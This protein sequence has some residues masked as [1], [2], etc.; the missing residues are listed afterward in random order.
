[1]TGREREGLSPTQRDALDHFSGIVKRYGTTGD[2]WYPSRATAAALRRLG[3][4]AEDYQ[5]LTIAGQVARATGRLPAATARPKRVSRRVAVEIVDHMRTD[6]DMLRDGGKSFEEAE[7]SARENA[8]Q[9]FINER[10][11]N[12]EGVWMAMGPMKHRSP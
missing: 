5:T 4:L 6:F 10:G 1:M 11:Y 9:T 3:L 8:A 7:L 12:R 2:R